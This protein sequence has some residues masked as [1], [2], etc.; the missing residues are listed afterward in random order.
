MELKGPRLVIKECDPSLLPHI[1]FDEGDF[2]L[3]PFVGRVENVV[4]FVAYLNDVPIGHCSTYNPS[5]H[6]VEFGITIAE[7]YR[8]KGYGAEA[9]KVLSDYYLSTLG[10]SKVH[11]KVL[12]HNG[13]AIRSYEKAGF[14]RCGKVVVDTIEFIK[15]EKSSIGG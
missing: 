11:L 12:P 4:Y 10:F 3:D 5:Q 7:G 2:A 13:R 6:E 1:P 9:I 14:T 8:S 15:M